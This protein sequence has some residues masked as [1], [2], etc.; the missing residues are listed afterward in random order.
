MYEPGQKKECRVVLLFIV[1]YCLIAAP[2][3]QILQTNFNNFYRCNIAPLEAVRVAVETAL[4][5]APA[6]VLYVCIVIVMDIVFV[7]VFFLLYR[8]L[9]KLFPAKNHP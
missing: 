1:G 5:Y 8:L 7:Q 4:G 9:Q 2:M 3:A 6:Q